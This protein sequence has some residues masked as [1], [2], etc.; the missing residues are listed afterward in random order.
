MIAEEILELK[1]D[2]PPKLLITGD[3]IVA[4]SSSSAVLLT[5]WSI[6]DS[7]ELIELDQID[8]EDIDDNICSL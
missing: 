1:D 2:F 5:L 8:G 3:V 7:L 4:Y 6:E